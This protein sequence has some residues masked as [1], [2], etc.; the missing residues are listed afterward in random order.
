[1]SRYF[2]EVIACL[3]RTGN[4]YVVIHG[5]LNLMDVMKCRPVVAVVTLGCDRH[6]APG[7]ARAMVDTG[8]NG[9]LARYR[10]E[11]FHARN[12]WFGSLILTNFTIG[13]RYS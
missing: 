2:A 9:G 6:F 10:S 7:I 3:C 13:E 8:M 5:Y 4:S 11:G 1:M 12:R